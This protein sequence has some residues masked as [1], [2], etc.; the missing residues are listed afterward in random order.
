MNN[1][2]G[3]SI[4]LS[5]KSLD[6]LW[7]KQSVT[8]TN[9]ANNETPGYKA[10]YVTF[11]D[12]YRSRLRAASGNSRD[13]R[14]AIGRSEWTVHESEV[15]SSRSDGN[16]VVIDTEQTELTRAALQYQYVIQSLNSDIT[17][18]STVIKG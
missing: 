7:Y 13:V 17:R 16:N 1:I 8:L 10:K 14:A 11:E 2:F 4:Q 15:E 12:T 5:E 6:Y 3:N 18:L 9:I